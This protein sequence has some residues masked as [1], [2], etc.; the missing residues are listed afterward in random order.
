MGKKEDIPEKPVAKLVKATK[1]LLKQGKDKSYT[2]EKARVIHPESLVPVDL[3]EKVNSLY[4]TSGNWYEVKG[5][6]ED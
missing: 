3:V 4:K 6:K 1:Y 5:S 2:K